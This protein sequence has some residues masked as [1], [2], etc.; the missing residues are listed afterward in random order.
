MMKPRPRTQL[1]ISQLRILQTRSE[2]HCERAPAPLQ[3]WW[4]GGVTQTR[5]W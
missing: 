2:M 5:K 3:S 1:S 4:R